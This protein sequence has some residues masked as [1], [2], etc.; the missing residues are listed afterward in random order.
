M[1]VNQGQKTGAIQTN[2]R[3]RCQSPCIAA[4]QLAGFHQIAIEE[5][6]AKPVANPVSWL[7]AEFNQTALNHVNSLDR[8]SSSIDKRASRERQ[9]VTLRMI[10]K[11]LQRSGFG[12]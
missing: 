9:P 10:Q 12:R 11:Q 1:F 4:V 2:Q 8:F 7:D 6:F 5:Q 3:K